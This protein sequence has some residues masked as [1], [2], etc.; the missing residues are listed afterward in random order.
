MKNLSKAL[1]FSLFIVG[2]STATMAAITRTSVNPSTVGCIDTFVTNTPGTSYTWNFGPNSYPRTFTSALPAA[3]TIFLT[4]GT[5]TVS[6]TIT[7][8]GGP[9]NETLNVTVQA[10]TSNI[11]LT[12]FPTPICQGVATTFTAGTTYASYAFFINDSL[13][14]L[15]SSSAFQAALGLND[16]VRVFG[17]NGGCWSNASTVFKANPL[18]NAAALTSSIT[19]DTICSGDLVVFTASPSGQNRYLFYNGGAQQQST[20][21]NTWSTTQL[22]QGNQV[23]V[24]VEDA[25]GCQS[26]WSNVIR[27]FVKPTPILNLSY[28]PGICYGEVNGQASVNPTQGIPPYNILW[29]N[30]STNDTVYNFASGNFSVTVSGANSCA[31]STSGTFIPSTQIWYTSILDLR[32]CAEPAYGNLSIVDTGGTGGPGSRTYTLAGFASNTTGQFS[33][34]PPGNYNFSITD[35]VGCTSN[36]IISIPQ[37]V[38]NAQFNVTVQPASCNANDGSI[39]ITPQDAQ[40][41]VFQYSLNGGGYQFD[42]AFRN[43]PGG[44][45]TI[46]I[47]NLVFGCTYSLD[48]VVP[49]P[50]QLG[51]NATPDSIIGGPGETHQVTVAVTGADLPVYT[52]SPSAGLSC[53]DCSNPVITTSTNT[54][55]YVTVSDE[56]SG[57]CSGFDSIV[58]IIAGEFDM[59]DA[60]APGGNV[61]QNL[62]F[63]PVS[64]GTININT[65]RIYNRWGQMVHNANTAWDGKFSS[66]D[67]PVGT[68]V[69]YI[70]LEVPDANSPGGSK[71]E[72]RNGSVTLVR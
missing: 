30:G 41:G 8:G 70:E 63:G 20:S 46:G 9:V 16:S 31:A 55:Y 71:V 35:S 7:T 45:Y 13:K 25:N 43:L 4:P 11:T 65:F 48:T 37:G 61:P 72:K 34:I 22:G 26:A 60:F 44:D 42:T 39:T 28:R 66:K 57:N 10:S 24:I 3:G 52:W 19:N 68:Y 64:N 58:V 1:L 32:L 47:K 15:S 49:Q 51:V 18:P 69:Y 59:P 21:A 29:S 23:I 50:A 12:A 38:S 40:S 27:T 6:L 17:T 33:N 14:Q 67:Q 54:V 2:F 36:G 5:R 56:E 62:T 53:T